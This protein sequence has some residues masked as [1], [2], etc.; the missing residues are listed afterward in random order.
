MHFVLSRL[1]SFWTFVISRKF[2]SVRYSERKI[3]I[4]GLAKAKIANQSQACLAFM[5]KRRGLS[6]FAKFFPATM[7]VVFHCSCLRLHG[8]EIAGEV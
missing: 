6:G 3:V 4:L 7:T 2:I 8:N 1:D 5:L